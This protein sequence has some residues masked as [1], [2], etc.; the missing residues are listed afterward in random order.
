MM[1]VQT[2]LPSADRMASTWSGS[3]IAKLIQL[4]PK[5]KPSPTRGCRY[6]V[7]TRSALCMSRPSR[8]S[9]QS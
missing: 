8:F 4:A 6:P 7:S 9:I 5:P 1:N 2:Q 3:T